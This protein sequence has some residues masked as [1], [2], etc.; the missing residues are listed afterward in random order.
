VLLAL[1][2][3]AIVNLFVELD[4]KRGRLDALL[5]IQECGFADV[6][7]LRLAAVAASNAPTIGSRLPVSP[8]AFAISRSA[9]RRPSTLPRRRAV[10][11][12][13]AQ[14]RFPR[15]RP[16]FQRGLERVAG[17]SMVRFSEDRRPAPPHARRG[18]R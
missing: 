3:D 4:E 8:R 18:A 14:D 6:V 17:R 16:R 12:R 15:R 7:E 5:G 11:L 10:S 9:S 2:S 1:G 13:V